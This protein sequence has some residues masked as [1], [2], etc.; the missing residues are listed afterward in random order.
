MKFLKDLFTRDKEIL[1]KTIIEP[2]VIFKDNHGKV[3]FHL[4]E[5]NKGKR[6]VVI[7]SSFTDIRHQGSF[8]ESAKRF[9]T[10]QEKIVRWLAGRR[11][12]EIPSYSEIGQEDVI[13]QLKGHI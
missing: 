12:P 10:Y 1:V 7:D 9:D 8:N 3:Y 5:S 6:R 4:Y 11:D 13:N 2:G